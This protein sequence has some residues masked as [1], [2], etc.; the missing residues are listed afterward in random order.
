MPN[1]QELTEKQKAFAEALPT[2]GF[3]RTKAALLA[4]PGLTSDSA[5]V[6]G[7]KQARN[8]RIRKY[9]EKLML[10]VNPENV[11]IKE[12]SAQA[13]KVG[14]SKAKDR[15]KHLELVARM[16]KIIGDDQMKVPYFAQLNQFVIDKTGNIEI[17]AQGLV[18]RLKMSA[19]G[20]VPDQTDNDTSD[21]AHK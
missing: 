2:V 10:E 20:I 17:T 6:Y 3:N 12:I 7:S 4:Y 14:F 21:K 11:G 9:I 13:I 8:P 19:R 18:S 1:T 15:Y 5:A 16:K